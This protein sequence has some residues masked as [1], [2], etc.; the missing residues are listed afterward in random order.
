MRFCDIVPFNAKLVCLDKLTG[1]KCTSCEK[2]RLLTLRCFEQ[3]KTTSFG[4]A[5]VLTLGQLR[6]VVNLTDEGSSPMVI[7]FP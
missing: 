4:K 7:M 2:N 3:H 1:I 6:A 5:Q